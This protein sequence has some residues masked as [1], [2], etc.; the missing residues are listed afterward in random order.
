MLNYTYLATPTDLSS[1]DSNDL[2]VYDYLALI[3]LA[4]QEIGQDELNLMR[5][6]LSR[7]MSKNCLVVISSELAQAPNDSYLKSIYKE[8]FSDA[9]LPDTY[10]AVATIYPDVND[11]LMFAP[12]YRSLSPD[13]NSRRPFYAA[14]N[15]SLQRLK[16]DLAYSSLG[17]IPLPD[18]PIA[19]QPLIIPNKK[20]VISQRNALELNQTDFAAHCTVDRKTISKAENGTLIKEITLKRMAEKLGVPADRLVFNEVVPQRKKLAELRTSTGCTSEELARECGLTLACFFDLIEEADR[21]PS[22]VI[23][24]V[25]HCYEKLLATERLSFASLINLDKTDALNS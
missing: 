6:A 24:F 16:F 2:E 15:Q 9:P 4:G 17:A 25:H 19:K 8:A 18:L 7:F 5:A 23:R 12:V 14:L 10:V 11:R 13:P 20:A 22:K 1:F 21:L 3:G